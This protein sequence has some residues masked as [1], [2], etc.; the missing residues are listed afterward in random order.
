MAKKKSRTYVIDLEIEGGKEAESQLS[1]VNEELTEM[2]ENGDSG[3]SILDEL[4]GGFGNVAGKAKG[5]IG[6]VKGIVKGLGTLKGAIIATGVGAFII[7]LT[8]VTTWLNNTVEG[9]ERLRQASSKLGGVWD[10]VKIKFAAAGESIVNAIDNPQEAWNDFRADLDKGVN[11]IKALFTLWI[12]DWKIKTKLF[13]KGIL[14]MRVKWN[15]FTGDAEEAEKLTEAIEGINEELKGLVKENVDAQI[16]IAA[17]AQETVNALKAEA[18]EYA[19]R[20]AQREDLVNATIELEKRERALTV[21]TA[22][23]RA[24]IERQKLIADDITKSEEERLA[25]ANTAFALENN[26]MQERE[27]LQKE[28]IRLTKIEMET[29]LTSNED[30]DRLAEQEAELARIQQES[31]TRQIELNNKRKNLLFHHLL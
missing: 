29:S 21:A 23:Q 5:V 17:T 31:T 15:E 10:E 26:L 19:K 2:S 12:N 4:G 16:T 24:E 25:A 13:Q 8:S 11:V 3:V 6:S 18:E 28:R 1:A 30:L 14:E 22:E 20:Q 27:A 7:A 9:S